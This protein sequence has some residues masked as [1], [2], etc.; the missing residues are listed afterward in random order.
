MTDFVI[1]VILRIRILL[2][3]I[4]SM[5]KKISKHREFI[6][7]NMLLLAAIIVIGIV[8]LG[9]YAYHHTEWRD[10]FNSLYFTIVTMSTIGYWDVVPLTHAWK[11]LTMVFAF[12]GVPMFIAL[13]GVILESRF[14]KIMQY[15]LFEYNKAIKKTQWEIKETQEDLEDITHEV[16]KVEK[17]IKEDAKM[18]ETAEKDMKVIKKD[19]NTLQKKNWVFK[20]SRK[21][22]KN[23]INK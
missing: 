8:I 20:W 4:I 21:W 23:K 5:Q 12:L 17:V 14:R 15:H 3:E 9:A 6:D 10:F 16:K 11:A 13:S 7:N 18:A 22:L 1:L 19:L 2:K